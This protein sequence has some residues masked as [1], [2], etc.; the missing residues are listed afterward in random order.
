MNL[1]K[2]RVVR[3]DPLNSNVRLTQLLLYILNFKICF[4]DLS[5]QLMYLEFFFLSVFD[6]S[7]HFLKVVFI[8]D[9]PDL[10]IPVVI[11]QIGIG[12]VTDLLCPV[13]QFFKLFLHLQVFI[14]HLHILFFFFLQ[15]KT[16][17]CYFLNSFVKIFLYFGTD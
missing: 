10:S 9:I 7:M 14:K 2:G 8:F 1:Y 13:I 17:L 4:S 15:T 12:S 6:L 5:L 11:A 16:H 3:A